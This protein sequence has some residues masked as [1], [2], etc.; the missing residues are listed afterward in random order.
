MVYSIIRSTKTRRGRI[1][2]L[3]GLFAPADGIIGRARRSTDS[4]HAC[5]WIG[6]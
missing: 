4:A 6:R 1:Y 5:I 2:S 3:P